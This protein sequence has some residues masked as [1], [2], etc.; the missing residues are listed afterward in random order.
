MDGCNEINHIKEDFKFVALLKACAKKK[1]LC[2]GTKLHGDILKRR[3]LLE[4]SPYLACTLIS[5]YAKCGMIAKAQAVLDHLPYRNVVCWNALLAGYG[6]HGQGE[7]A[8]KCFERMKK[9]GFSPNAITYLCILKACCSGGAIRNGQVI[10]A[11]IVEIGLDGN[12]V[13]GSSI[14]GMYASS[15]FFIDANN[16]FDK[17]L[18]RDVV[19]WTALIG[20]YFW[21]CPARAR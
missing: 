14:V 9:E 13:V 6:Q 1:N 2:E 21:I 5:M 10:H 19:S 16:V 3:G 7:E 8:L 15:G 4:K 12:H 18:N 11:N 20:G 17:I